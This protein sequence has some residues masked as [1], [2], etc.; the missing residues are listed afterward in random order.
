[1]FLSWEPHPALEHT[2]VNGMAL[3][4]LAVAA[5]PLLSSAASLQSQLPPS[6]AQHRFLIVLSSSSD[7]NDSW[8]LLYWGLLKS[9]GYLHPMS[10][11]YLYQWR[12]RVVSIAQVRGVTLPMQVDSWSPW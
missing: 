12:N 8:V 10:Q 7:L 5:Q 2:G 6:Y 3:M 11:Q 1:M 9:A 4:F